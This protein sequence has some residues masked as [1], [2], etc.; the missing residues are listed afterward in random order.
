MVKVLSL[1]AFA[2]NNAKITVLNRETGESVPF[3]VSKMG[4]GAI[5]VPA[6]QKAALRIIL[7][8]EAVPGKSVAAKSVYDLDAP[9][10]GK[11]SQGHVAYETVNITKIQ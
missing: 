2:G 1:G 8:H 9:G 10:A 3:K 4:A 7:E 5:E 11:K 6:L